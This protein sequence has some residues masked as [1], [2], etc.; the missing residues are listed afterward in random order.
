MDKGIKAGS[1]DCEADTPTTKS[2]RWFKL[3][4]VSFLS[5]DN[6]ER[7]SFP[8]VVE[9]FE[10]GRNCR[11]TAIVESKKAMQWPTTSKAKISETFLF[12]GSISNDEHL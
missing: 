10:A 5:H 9:N 3:V 12:L 7:S 2:P 11:L 8:T 6:K 4:N 1:M